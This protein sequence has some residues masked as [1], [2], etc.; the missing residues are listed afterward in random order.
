MDNI[1]T[2]NEKEQA[3]LQALAGL[4][5]SQREAIETIEGPVAVLAGPGT[6]KTQVL[7]LRIANI[8][9]KTDTAPESILALTYTEQGAR[10][11]RARLRGFI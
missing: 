6:G 5:E 7:T 3:F 9:F 2:K 8:L 4:N 11:M 10:A 1:K